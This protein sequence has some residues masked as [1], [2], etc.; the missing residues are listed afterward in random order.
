MN[1]AFFISKNCLSIPYLI[2][3]H[4]RTVLQ[5]LQRGTGGVSHSHKKQ[6]KK[7]ATSRCLLEKK[8]GHKQLSIPTNQTCKS[9]AF[10]SGA[11]LQ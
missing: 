7:Y 2:H 10:S 3:C 1:Q 9:L 6:G 5:V 8:A 11:D 4:L